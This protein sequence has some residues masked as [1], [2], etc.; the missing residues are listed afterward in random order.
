MAPTRLSSHIASGAELGLKDIKEEPRMTRN[1]PE[2]IISAFENLEQYCLENSKLQSEEAIARAIR[3]AAFES[4]SEMLDAAN[5][6]Q[7]ANAVKA[8]LISN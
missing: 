3:K 6:V 4:C 1:S 8:A 5:A 7:A 2:W